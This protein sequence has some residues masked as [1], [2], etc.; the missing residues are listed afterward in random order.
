MPYE[1]KASGLEEISEMLEKLE[2]EAPKAAAKAL[3]KGAGEMARAITSAIDSI[4]T[5]P[6]R[7]A[8]GGDTRLPSPQE[9][10]V[11]KAAGGLGIAK[12]S[13][14]GTEID[15]SVGFGKSGYAEMVGRAV[16]IPKIA[17]AINSGTSFMKKQPFFRKGVRD[18]TK[19]AE[20]AIATSIEQEIEKIVK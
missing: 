19:A 13:K 20:T 9:K 4:Q 6:F 1:M 16:P 10:A 18:G 14:N 11:L 12:F 8:S 5:A 7:F 17:N 3:Y 2:T 15:T